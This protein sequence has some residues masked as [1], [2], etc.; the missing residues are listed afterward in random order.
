M[1]VSGVL[2][3]WLSVRPEPRFSG[4]PPEFQPIAEFFGVWHEH[5]RGNHKGLH[6]FVWNEHAY[7]LLINVHEDIRSSKR[8]FGVQDNSYYT[9][10]PHNAVLLDPQTFDK[11]ILIESKRKSLGLDGTPAM[12]AGESCDV[13]SDSIE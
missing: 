5:Q 13:V 12:N 9:L 1:V 11:K 2:C 7:V 10:K 4:T 3:A 6:E 8:E